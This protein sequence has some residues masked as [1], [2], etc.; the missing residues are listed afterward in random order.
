M[1]NFQ[2]RLE[3]A[4]LSATGYVVSAL[5][6]LLPLSPQMLNC[7][8]PLNTPHFLVKVSLKA[9]LRVLLSEGR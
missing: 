7:I 2:A 4:R 1:K 8:F 3:L 9:Q 6:S 5:V